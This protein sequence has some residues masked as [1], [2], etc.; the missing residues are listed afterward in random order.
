MSYKC[1]CKPRDSVI[2]ASTY[3]VGVHDLCA[4]CHGIYEVDWNE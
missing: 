1:K 4:K 3:Q 2:K